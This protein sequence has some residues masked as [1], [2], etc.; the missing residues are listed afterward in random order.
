MFYKTKAKVP[1]DVSPTVDQLSLQVDR[2]LSILDENIL[3]W[4]YLWSDAYVSTP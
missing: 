1:K 3:L 2:A 4:E